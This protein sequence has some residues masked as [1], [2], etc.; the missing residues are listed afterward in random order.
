MLRTSLLSSFVLAVS[1]TI[2]GCGDHYSTQDA[3]AVC[4]DFAA[5]N[6]GNHPDPSFHDCVACYETCGD[7]CEQLGSA[8]ENYACPDELG[9][10]G[11]GGGGGGG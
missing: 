10:S 5:R 3:Y 6:P 1:L 4:E 2:A 8:P 9:A 11:I 7:E